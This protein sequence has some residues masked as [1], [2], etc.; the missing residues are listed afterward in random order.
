MKITCRYCGIVEKPHR[1][2]KSNKIKR[3]RTDSKAY[4]KKGYK[5]VRLEVLEDYNFRD[6]FSLFVL[7]KYVSAN[8]THH[9]V[10]VLEDESK[11][12][13]Y[14]NLIPVAE[15]THDLIHDLYKIDK[16]KTQVILR[17]MLK[18]STSSIESLG[19]YKEEIKEIYFQ[20][21]AP[22]PKEF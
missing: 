15:F 1:C 2:P 8:V 18:D 22:L 10:E 6:L 14:D 12:E 16:E 11:A 7:G 13:D 3:S 5:R 9:I 17:R 20:N 19:K 4:S 21:G